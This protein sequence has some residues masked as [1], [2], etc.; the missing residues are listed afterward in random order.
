MK[1]ILSSNVS[2]NTHANKVIKVRCISCKQET[3]HLIIVD[4]EEYQVDEDFNPWV[5]DYQIVKCSGCDDISFRKIASDNKEAISAYHRDDIIFYKSIK[6]ED[7]Y[8][9]RHANRDPLKEDEIFKYVPK[10]IIDIYREV[11]ETINNNLTII[12]PI[13]LRVLMEAICNDLIATE[14]MPDNI[15]NLKEKIDFLVKKGYLQE[16]SKDILHRIRTIGNESAHEC[17]EQKMDEILL[18]IEVIEALIKSLYI[19][20]KRFNKISKRLGNPGTLD[21]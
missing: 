3:N 6:Y 13:G 20:P 12:L 4:Y 17:E 21:S 11:N 8:P 5:T 7:L 2:T 19:H 14:V 9:S 10:K 15:R 1:Y 18:A 16:I